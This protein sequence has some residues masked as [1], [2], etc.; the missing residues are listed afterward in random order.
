MIIATTVTS[1]FSYDAILYTNF[2]STQKIPSIFYEHKIKL[3]LEANRIECN[4]YAFGETRCPSCP[5]RSSCKSEALPLV[6]K[7]FNYDQLLKEYPEYFL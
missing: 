4:S 1:N 6:K 2:S 7:L 5:V 3:N